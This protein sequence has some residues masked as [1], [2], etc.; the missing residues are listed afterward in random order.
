MYLFGRQQAET[1]GLVDTVS[2]LFKKINKIFKT[3]NWRFVIWASI[4]FSNMSGEGSCEHNNE[5]LGSIK[6]WEVLEWLHNSSAHL[7]GVSAAS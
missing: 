6:C 3:I 5:T 2:F 7:H 4:K 1:L